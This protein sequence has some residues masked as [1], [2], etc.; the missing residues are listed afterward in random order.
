MNINTIYFLSGLAITLLILYFVLRR[1]G[2]KGCMTAGYI[3]L[4]IFSINSLTFTSWF[5]MSSITIDVYSVLT[6][7]ENYTAKVVSFTSERRRDSDDG[8]YTTMYTPTVIFKT[9]KDSV[10]TKTLSFSTSSLE[11]GDTY[12]VNYNT[13]TGK[14]ITL[15]FT[16]VMKFIGSFIFCLIF[17]FLFLG[18]L[19]Y[20]FG[21]SMS[22]YKTL[23]S[24]IG[25]YFLIPFFMIGFTCLMIYGI[26]FGND[27]P[28][29]V[30]L[31]LIFFSFVLV[32]ATLGY[33]KMLYTK[34]QPQLKR[35]R[36][37]KRVG[38]FKNRK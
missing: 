2:K 12:R 3:G 37:N 33:I 19:L 11:I 9:Q 4:V 13:N 15:G 29:W 31:V 6:S 22:G 10:L 1:L 26:L 28:F 20:A 16:L 24:K 27:V 14:V 18:I 35:V 34:G 5:F 25:F 21:Y 38:D 7:G 32:L 23:V 30:T 36:A 17:S 8:G